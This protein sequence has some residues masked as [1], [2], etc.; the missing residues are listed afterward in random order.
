MN[1]QSITKYAVATVLGLGVVLGVSSL[2]AAWTTPPSAPPGSNVD[3]PINVGA[4][5]QSKLGQL[6][7]NTDAN[8]PFTT[9]LQVF[10][11]SIFNG[12]VQILSGTPGANKVLTS[13]A[14]GNASWAT[15]T[16]GSAGT[17][18]KIFTY[19]TPATF[20]SGVSNWIN[21]SLPSGNTMTAA[22]VRYGGLANTA[23][24]NGEATIGEF[25][26]AQ[27]YVEVDTANSRLKVH[28]IGD[29]HVT[30]YTGTTGIIDLYLTIYTGSPSG[31]GGGSASPVLLDAPTVLYSRTTQVA[32][33]AQSGTIQAG[34]TAGVPA[35]AKS[36]LLYGKVDENSTGVTR[37]IRFKQPLQ[38]NWKNLV[39]SLSP[40]YGVEN[41]VSV[42]LDTNGQL[43][44]QISA[45]AAPEDYRLEIQGYE[46]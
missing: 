11:K 12:T 30:P 24:T 37:Y 32:D 36:V 28:L 40:L 1:K 10:G 19:H 45:S 3:A 6:F 35:G 16:G 39:Y 8:T 18:G 26:D 25:R 29:D 15:P 7:I 34:T 44:W 38:T 41:S 5:S 46:L 23:M 31:G 42:P 14:T 21:I 17:W 2:Q 4:N 13:D 20:S 33:S 9:G 22:A 27:T 43:N